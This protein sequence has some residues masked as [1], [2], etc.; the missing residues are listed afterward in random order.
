MLT[1]ICIG[2]LIGIAGTAFLVRP[3]IHFFFFKKEELRLFH[4]FILQDETLCLKKGDTEIIQMNEHQFAIHLKNRYLDF[5][6][7]LQQRRVEDIYNY[8]P[9]QLYKKANAS[10]VDG[11]EY[12]EW[13]VETDEGKAFSCRKKKDGSF[14]SWKPTNAQNLLFH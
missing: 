4:L 5:P 1:L 9:K 8:L 7:M 3:Y 10:N 6:Y 11:P 13:S 14:G 2:I 12:T